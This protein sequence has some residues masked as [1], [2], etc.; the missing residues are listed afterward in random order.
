M[1]FSS[2]GSRRKSLKEKG[3]KETFLPF[4]S[5]ERMPDGADALLPVLFI[6]SPVASLL[7]AA[8]TCPA[9]EVAA[10]GDIFYMVII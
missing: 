8:G 9:P 5:A 4:V 6:R 2:T 10:A 7:P 1:L 3:R